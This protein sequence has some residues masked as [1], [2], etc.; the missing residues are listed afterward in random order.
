MKKKGLILLLA[1]VLLFCSCNSIEDKGLSDSAV[2]LSEKKKA[3]EA[4]KIPLVIDEEE[5]DGT[6]QQREGGPEGCGR[7]GEVRGFC[8]HDQLGCAGAHLE[9][10]NGHAAVCAAPGLLDG[11]EE[12][13]ERPQVDAG[14]RVHA[15][16]RVGL[17]GACGKSGVPSEAGS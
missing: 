12:V 13:G 2:I 17:A 11:L 1:G 10:R 7:L 6:T 4:K 8:T 5:P 16:H 15:Q 3:N 9:V 14:L